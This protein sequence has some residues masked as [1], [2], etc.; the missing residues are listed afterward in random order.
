M[1]NGVHGWGVRY[2][3]GQRGANGLV[4][5]Q[6]GDWRPGEEVLESLGNM[7]GDEGVDVVWKPF[8]FTESREVHHEARY[9]ASGALDDNTKV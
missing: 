3:R 2:V 5:C 6:L 9:F 1:D 8:E 7:A 4:E